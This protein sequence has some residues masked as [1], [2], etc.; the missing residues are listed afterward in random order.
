[1]AAQQL[2]PE[3][4]ITA[5][6]AQIGWRLWQ[7]MTP[8]QRQEQSFM[9]ARALNHSVADELEWP[10]HVTIAQANWQAGRSALALVAYDE[11]LVFAQA[12][13]AW[14]ERAADGAAAQTLSRDLY[15]IAA[16]AAARLGQIEQANKWFSIAETQTTSL[17]DRAALAQE[18]MF[19]YYLHGRH[20]AAIDEALTT[21]RL[22]GVQ[23]PRQPRRA[24]VG[25]ALLRTQLRL[26]GKPTSRLT[27]LPPM[28]DARRIKALELLVTATI[29]AATVAPLLFVL[30]GLEI[31]RQTLKHGAHPLSAMGYALYGVLLCGVTGQIERGY[32]FGQLA[33]Q[34]A[35]QIVI[36]EYRVFVNYF[37]HAHI[38]HWKEPIQATLQPLRDLATTGEFEYLALAAGLY[39]YLTWFISGMDLSTS[40]QAIAENMH[41]LTAYQGTP[42]YYRYQFGQQYY[43]NL[44]GLAPQPAQLVGNVYDEAQMLPIHRHEND[45]TTLFYLACHKVTLGYIFNDYAAA[46]AAAQ[47]ARAHQD[48][49]VGTPLIPVLVF[50]ESLA[51]LALYPTTTGAAARQHLKV[52][53]ANQRKMGRWAKHSPANCQHRYSLVA[54]EAARVRGANG[55]ARDL[56][57]AAIAQAGAHAYLPELAVAHEVTAR[58][59]LSNG[60]RDYAEHHLRQAQRC[61]KEWGA[62]GKVQQL[63]QCFPQLLGEIPNPDHAQRSD[64]SA[65]LDMAGVLQVTHI[66]SGEATLTRLLD[67]LTT[68]LVENAGAQA[69]ALLLPEAGQWRVASQVPHRA[70]GE[71]PAALLAVILNLVQQAAHT[72]EPL[73]L[74][75]VAADR[76]PGADSAFGAG[77]SPARSLLPTAA[78]SRGSCWRGSSGTFG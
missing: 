47:V 19:A 9:L 29:S 57:D 36:K 21:L 58:F 46:T 3:H 59:Y 75:D 44:L 20:D 50:Y 17:L 68:T 2:Y 42:L 54:A 16:Q 5:L 38:N 4:T 77:R 6:Q 37:V 41:L 35:P 7:R 48:G 56:Y 55:R 43:Q 66:L 40:E 10:A 14:L 1:M 74:N 76:Q 52:V 62:M 8:A 64:L 69:G 53:A 13:L 60:Q 15:L 18:R 30:L 33:L 78:G 49:G 27:R 45:Q 51:R 63:D 31:V 32:A 34:L 28:T 23:I 71:D 61:Y 67:T 24:H 26:P 39:P 70:A 73:L 65:Y 11:A 12:G 22:L 72:G 25:L